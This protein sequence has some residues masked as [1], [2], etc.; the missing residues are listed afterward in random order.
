V[1]ARSTPLHAGDSVRHHPRSSECRGAHCD[2]R[3]SPA[4][5]VSARMRQGEPVRPD[6]AHLRH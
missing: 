3:S 4:P 1:R 6:R 5:S 2:H